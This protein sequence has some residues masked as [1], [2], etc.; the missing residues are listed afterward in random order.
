MH[1]NLKP[2]SSARSVALVTADVH[3]SARA[4]RKDSSVPKLR[5]HSFAISLDGYG[6]GPNQDSDNPIGVGGIALHGI[7][8]LTRFTA[9]Y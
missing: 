5:V 9:L 3:L 8:T 2:G 7:V 4:Y 6:A 1:S